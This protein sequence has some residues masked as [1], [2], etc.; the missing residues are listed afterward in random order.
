MLLV[1][2]RNRKELSCG[3][4]RTTNNRME[5]LAAIAGLEQL[6]SSCRVVVSSDSKYL[7][8]AMTK[9]WLKGWKAKG[10]RRGPGKR[11][12]NEDLWKRLDAAQAGHEVAWKWVRGHAGHAENERCD[13][14]A[15]RAAAGR[16][17]QVDEGFLREVALDEGEARLL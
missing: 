13:E 9:G 15:V 12:K 14:L 6:K 7:I 1:S 8:N 16:D 5:L 10:W 2:G 4:A 17:L 11:L 3:Y